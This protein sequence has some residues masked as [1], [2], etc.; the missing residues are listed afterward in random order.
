LHEAVSGGLAAVELKTVVPQLGVVE[1]VERSIG[2]T[3]VF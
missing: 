3:L 1:E 2:D